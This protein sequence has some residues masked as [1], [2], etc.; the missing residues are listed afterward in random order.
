MTNYT[1]DIRTSDTFNVIEH[2]FTD[3]VVSEP[4]NPDE[5][6]FI[7]QSSITEKNKEIDAS[8]NT[9]VNETEKYGGDTIMV[10]TNHKQ[11][12]SWCEIFL[13]RVKMA[14]VPTNRKHCRGSKIC[15]KES[16]KDDGGNGDYQPQALQR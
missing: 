4:I 16:E 9:N 3:S 15:V 1:L 2:W 10:T 6:D 14:M 5:F 12:K 7:L 11:N 8:M 13:K